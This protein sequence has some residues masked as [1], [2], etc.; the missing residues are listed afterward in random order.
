M[1]EEFQRKF[2]VTFKNSEGFFRWNRKFQQ[3]YK[4]FVEP[5]QKVKMFTSVKHSKPQEMLNSNT[6]LT[7]HNHNKVVK[8]Y[9][10]LT[11]MH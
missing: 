3:E 9:S 4:V 5:P 6:L 11:R 8:S 1:N 2:D 10:E 7:L